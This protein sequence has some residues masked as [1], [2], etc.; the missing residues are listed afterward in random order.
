MPAIKVMSDSLASR[1]AAGEVVERPASVVKELVENSLDAG[2]SAIHIEIK[3]GGLRLIRVVDDGYGI[4]SDQLATA[5]QRF[6]TSKI[7]E[8]SDLLAISTLGFRG[9]AL[10]SIAAVAD[11]TAR[12]KHIDAEH[13]SECNVSFGSSAQVISAG[14]PNGTSVQVRQLFKNVPARRKFLGSAAAESARIAALVSQMALVRSDVKFHLVID[15]SVRVDTPGDFDDAATLA[16]VHRVADPSVIVNLKADP[17]GLFSVEGAIALPS[18]HYGRRSHITV[19]VNGRLVQN[20]RLNYAVERAYQ[21]FLPEKRYPMALIKVNAPIEDVDVNIH[22]AKTEVRFRREG[23]VFSVIERT[24]REALTRRAPVREFS[25]GR[26]VSSLEASLEN[27]FARRRGFGTEGQTT[28]SSHE[29]DSNDKQQ[30]S[31]EAS[32][33]TSSTASDTST[34]RPADKQTRTQT[35]NTEPSADNRESPAE[36]SSK[37][38][39]DVLPRLRV[40][41]QAQ[42][43]YIVA[44]DENG[45]FLI[46]QHAAHERVRFEEIRSKRADN[47]SESQPLLSPEVLQL[48]ADQQIAYSDG[49]QWFVETGWDIE[50]FGGDSVLLRAVPQ[51][52]VERGT[53]SADGAAAAF[54]R[55]LDEMSE[56]A[57]AGNSDGSVSADMPWSERLIATMA[58]HSAVRAGDALSPEECVQIV[59]L[60]QRCE[61]PQSCPHGRPTMLLLTGTALEREFGRR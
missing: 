33:E 61:H 9:E 34:T 50:P 54:R 25:R 13:G 4:P 21:G 48:S 3:N 7:D 37:R 41:G 46:D 51:V 47:A 11:I 52:F 27:A 8:T 30:D 22:P 38:H 16:A 45:V 6:A 10:P 26:V 20:Y 2:A 15:R 35:P 17:E 44:E 56:P 40:L 31:D 57:R 36:Q 55:L 53:H 1:V 32:T 60:L 58:C 39:H 18:I 12:S 24:V 42:Q 5:F 29:Q 49:A 14:A 19:A 23:L 43:T 59:N 28:E